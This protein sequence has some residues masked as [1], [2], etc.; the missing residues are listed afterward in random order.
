MPIQK[1]KRSYRK[2]KYVLYKETLIDHREHLFTFLGAFFGIGIIG[3]LN[4][5]HFLLYDNLFLIGSFGASSVLIYALLTVRWL[6]RATLLAD[7]S[8]A[9]LW[10]LP[11]ISSYPV[12]FGCR[13]RWRW[14]VPSF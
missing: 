9:P 11:F 2:V 12:S 14:P 5:S 7:T 6:S 4:S 10:V 1:I 13:R 3:Y 8:F